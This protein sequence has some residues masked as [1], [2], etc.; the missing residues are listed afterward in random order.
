MT[1]RKVVRD[2]GTGRFV[3]PRE[4]VRRPRT[5]ERETVNVPKPKKGK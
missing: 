2:S 1:T 4:A 3:E 5:T